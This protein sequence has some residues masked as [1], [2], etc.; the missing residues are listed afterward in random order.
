MDDR[1]AVAQYVSRGSYYEMWR[2]A[3][4]RLDR[5]NPRPQYIVGTDPYWVEQ[6]DIPAVVTHRE[7]MT[8]DQVVARYEGLINRNSLSRLTDANGNHVRVDVSQ[9]P[10]QDIESWF[11]IFNQTGVAM[12]MGSMSYDVT[13]AFMYA[14][15]LDK[16]DELINKANDQLKSTQLFPELSHL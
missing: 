14:H 11:R 8:H 13:T 16:A 7:E 4:P 3:Q 1:L 6:D 15:L 12:S 9:I 10:Q 5:L 2:A